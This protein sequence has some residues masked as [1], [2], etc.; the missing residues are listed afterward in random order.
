MHEDRG[1]FT[2]WKLAE[3][4][5]LVTTYL[6]NEIVGIHIFVSEK[7]YRVSDSSSHSIFPSF[8]ITVIS[9]GEEERVSHTGTHFLI[10][11]WQSV[12]TSSLVVHSADIWQLPP[13]NENEVHHDLWWTFYWLMAVTSFL[14]MIID[15]LQITCIQMLS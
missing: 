12:Q 1:I 9:L 14:H 11:P 6:S 10:L 13:W 7:R 15:S 3:E 8:D 4:N 5:V 2:W